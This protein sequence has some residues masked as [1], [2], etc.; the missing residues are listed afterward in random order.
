MSGQSAGSQLAVP[1]IQRPVKLPGMPV[2]RDAAA[3][4]VT[5]SKRAQQPANGVRM[6][7]PGCALARR[8]RAHRGRPPCAAAA[9]HSGA[10][11]PRASSAC[12]WLPAAR[13]ECET[14]A[15]ASCVCTAIER[16][17]SQGQGHSFTGP[18]Q[19]HSLA[20]CA[21]R[22]RL[23]QRSST[24]GCCRSEA[25]S[26]VQCHAG[27]RRPCE[28]ICRVPALSDWLVGSL[29]A[30]VAALAH[31]P[32]WH[33]TARALSGPLHSTAMLAISLLFTCWC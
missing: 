18:P 23:S 22:H 11:P 17:G 19:A 4:S 30:P 8:Q 2:K 3:R 9:A 15:W 24:P 1:Y 25:D 27:C 28:Q 7:G 6:V 10:P 20:C 26:C 33:A 14:G 5:A 29:G 31:A 21:T 16:A 12:A 32:A 13:K